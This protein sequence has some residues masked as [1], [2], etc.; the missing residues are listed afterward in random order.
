MDLA[1]CQQIRQFCLGKNGRAII[2][3]QLIISNFHSTL[4]DAISANAGI[5]IV[6]IIVGPAFSLSLHHDLSHKT[7]NRLTIFLLIALPLLFACTQKEQEIRVDSVSVSPNTASLTIG[8]T[9]QLKASVSPSSA[10]KKDVTWSSSKSSVASVSASGLVTAVS[11]G[12]T[13]ITASAD[14][15]KGECTVSVSKGYIAVTEVKLDKT[16]LTLYEGEEET[17]TA[18][19][20]PSDATLRGEISWSSSNPDVATVDGGI[21]T[22]VSMG[23]ATITASLEGFKAECNV[24]VK[25]MEYGMIAITDLMPVDILPIIGQVVTGDIQCYD[26]IE[27]LRLA[28]A[29]RI[30]DMMWEY[31]AGKHSK[32]EYQQLMGRLN[33]GMI[34][35]F[36]LGYNNFEVIGEGQ[37]G[38]SGNDHAHSE[39]SVLNS[40]VRHANMRVVYTSGKEWQEKLEEFIT[41][42]PNAIVI[43]GCSAYADV[44]KD[45]FVRWAENEPVRN[46][47]RTGRLIIFKSG[48]NIRTVNGI[49]INLTYQRDVDGD[50]HGYYSLQSNA[51]GKDDPKAD[52]ALLVTTGTN[53]KG[54]ADQTGNVYTSARF[55]VG[56]HDKALFAGRAFPFHHLS[57]D[58]IWADKE[59]VHS[60]QASLTN[61]VNTAM[62]SLCFQMYAE[63]KDVFELLDMVRS[64]C[65]TDYIRLDGQTQPLQLINPAGLYKKYLTP[66]N[67]PS[68]ISSSETVG[69]EK[70]YYKG[71]LFCIPGAEVKIDGEWMAFD[72]KNRDTILSR[73]PMNLEWRLSGE[74]IKKYGYT[75]GQ[76]IEGQIITVD[77]HWGGL[78]LEVPMTIQLK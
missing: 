3:N 32:E 45:K 47:C 66:Q 73:N 16:E 39:W 15:K 51:N 35:E 65:L 25:G 10:T 44:G 17:L 4:N 21:V 74:L 9:L 77:D 1:D 62:M 68:S 26:H 29:T 40:L 54:D 76:T 63:A 19:I 5:F 31:G 72:S 27:H 23:N 2:C 78:R 18:T 46:L 14:G 50:E 52:I 34:E 36:P 38:G 6:H 37:Y 53:D 48:G 41:E 60:Y 12:T 11:E 22:A 58:E 61:Y 57:T 43:M 75:S 8:E 70:G 71:I 49:L 59:S 30:R 24:V 55:P 7:M 69:L 13:T 56:F 20:I 28:E 64:T 67:L 42:N 33:T